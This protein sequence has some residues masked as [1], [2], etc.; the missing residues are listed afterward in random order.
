MVLQSHGWFIKEGTPIKSMCLVV[1]ER[2]ATRNFLSAPCVTPSSERPE[3][4]HQVKFHELVCL[5]RGI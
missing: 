1:R 3:S 4:S 5:F 2:R